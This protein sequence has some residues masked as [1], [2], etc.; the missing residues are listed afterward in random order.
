MVLL[1]NF[2]SSPDP[3]RIVHSQITKM[4]YGKLMSKNVWLRISLI[5]KINDNNKNV[6]F[7]NTRDMKINKCISTIST[8]L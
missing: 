2:F 4:V 1:D 6:G 7:D 3:T 5:K 8:V